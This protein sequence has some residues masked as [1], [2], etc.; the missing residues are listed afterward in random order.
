MD[1][2]IDVN[3]DYRESE[4]VAA[5]HIRFLRSSRVIIIGIAG[6][7]G[8]IYL[9][10]QQFNLWKTYGDIPSTWYT[11]FFLP[12]IFLAAVILVYFLAP[13]IDFRQN[14]FWKYTYQLKLLPDNL[15]FSI[16]NKKS[17]LKYEWNDA[18]KVLEDKN[19]Y[20][21]FYSSE[22]NYLI[23]PKRILGD[24]ELFFRE[25]LSKAK[26]LSNKLIL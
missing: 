8:T 22:N 5:Q 9:A 6:I 17:G 13:V 16:K 7:I 19:V 1:E 12:L 14:S 24:N 25:R 15:Y 18:K 20:V 26:F 23:I 2:S 3:L 11:P 21:I 10:I 4:V